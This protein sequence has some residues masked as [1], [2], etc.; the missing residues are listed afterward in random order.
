VK[1]ELAT[2][3]TDGQPEEPQSRLPTLSILEQITLQLSTKLALPDPAAPGC[4]GQHHFN[5]V[6][7]WLETTQWTTYLRGHDLRQA[8]ALIGLPPSPAAI[9]QATLSEHESRS[10]EQLC[11]LLDSFDHVIEQARKSPLEDRVNVFD[12][13]QVNSFLTRRSFKRALSGTISRNQRAVGVKRS[14]SSCSASSTGSSG[15]SK[16]QSSIAV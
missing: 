8:A 5:Q 16:L 14:E 15:R 6:S 11:L 4:P 13:H 10:T 3:N 1:L 7:A 12:Q 9:P 2:T